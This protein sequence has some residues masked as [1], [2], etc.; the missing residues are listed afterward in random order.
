MYQLVPHPCF[1]PLRPRRNCGTSA[2]DTRKEK[3]KRIVVQNF[4]DFSTTTLWFG[5]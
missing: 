1:M 2:R 4:V 5:H 3:D